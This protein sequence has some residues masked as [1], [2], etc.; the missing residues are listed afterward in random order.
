MDAIN[1]QLARL[2]SLNGTAGAEDLAQIRKAVAGLMAHRAASDGETKKTREVRYRRPPEW[3]TFLLS[4]AASFYGVTV[5]IERTDAEAV[6]TLYGAPDDVASTWELFQ[7]VDEEVN[8]VAE[9]RAALVYFSEQRR[10][11]AR[12]KSK[13][14]VD[15][16]ECFR[17]RVTSL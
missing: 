1:R 13:I 6:A 16:A 4:A 11:P 10:M 17:R 7:L 5:T 9:A 14:K 8:A 2:V 3:F 12:E 15:L